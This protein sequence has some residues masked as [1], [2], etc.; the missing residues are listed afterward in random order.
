MKKAIGKWLNP[1]RK[2]R[3]PMEVN[4]NQS[5]SAGIWVQA[6]GTVVNTGMQTPSPKGGRRDLLV[7]MKWFFSSSLFPSVHCSFLLQSSISPL[8]IFLNE[9]CDTQTP[10]IQQDSPQPLSW[11]HES[12]R[13]QYPGCRPVIW[14][15]SPYSLER[16]SGPPERPVRCRLS[17]AEPYQKRGQD[18]HFSAEHSW[19]AY[20]YWPRKAGSTS[21]RVSALS[22]WLVGGLTEKFGVLRASSCQQ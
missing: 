15:Q 12:R 18:G 11:Q 16:A 8:S 22:C 1:V 13:V 20:V 10:A 7:R 5:T 19:A 6:I 3:I 2:R 4:H 9:H 17:H 14:K 21:A